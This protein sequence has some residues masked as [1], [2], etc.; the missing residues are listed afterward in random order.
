MCLKL[1][2]LG[3]L[4]F[5]DFAGVKASALVIMSPEG[6]EADRIASYCM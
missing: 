5:G 6:A 1:L 2:S 3:C 4:V